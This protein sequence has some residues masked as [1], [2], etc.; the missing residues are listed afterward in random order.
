[1][2]SGEKQREFREYLVRSTAADEIVKVL[3]G[4]EEAQKKPEEPVTFLRDMFAS[5]ELADVASR[6]FAPENVEE[7]LEQNSALRSRAESLSDE[8]A[9]K[10]ARITELV[11]AQQRPQLVELME[12]FKGGEAEGAGPVLETSK[13]YEELKK[14]AAVPADGEEPA[15]W[16]RSSHGNLRL[17]DFLEHCKRAASGETILEED[18]ISAARAKVATSPNDWL[19]SELHTRLP[20]KVSRGL[21]PISP[22]HPYADIEVLDRPF[23]NTRELSRALLLGEHN[24][25][26]YHDEHRRSEFGITPGHRDA[27]KGTPQHGNT[28]HRTGQLAILCRC[29]YTTVCDCIHTHHTRLFPIVAMPLSSTL[30]PVYFMFLLMGHPG[31]P[32]V[33]LLIRFRWSALA[34]LISVRGYI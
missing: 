21:A 9:S 12:M 23:P 3:V 31:V 30:Q 25:I 18:R 17:E 7:L 34:G 22:K 10:E 32:G 8:L 15:S 19:A 2:V 5:Q 28:K 33:A 24:E 26:I 27:P 13:L 1:M 20:M 14:L 16:W 6:R 29:I 11:Q 4:L